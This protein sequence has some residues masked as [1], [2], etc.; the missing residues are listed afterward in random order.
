MPK[1]NGFQ[2]PP[3]SPL[4]DGREF[5]LWR[6]TTTYKNVLFVDQQHVG[7]ADT[8]SG[9]EHAPFKTVQRAAEVVTPGTRVLIKSGIY[10]ECVSPHRG[11]SSQD[12]MISFEAAPGAHVV[13][14]GSEIL[15]GPWQLTGPGKVSVNVWMTDLP[16]ELFVGEHPFAL[17]NT[18]DEEFDIMRWAKH[19]RGKVP[20]TLR[21]AIVLQNGRRLTH[22]ASFED[23]SRVPGSFWI[24]ADN[25]RLHLNPLGRCHPDTVTFEATVRQYLFNPLQ[26]DLGFIKIKGLIFEHAGN[27]FVRSGNGAVNTWSGHH[28]IIENNTVRHINAVG[29]E[30]GAWIDEGIERAPREELEERTGDHVVCGNH[31]HDCGTGGIQGTVVARGLILNN[32]IHDCGW[33][34]AEPYWEV[35][36]IKILYTVDTLVQSNH[37]HDCYAGSAIWIDFMNRNTR[38]CR[39]LIHDVSAFTGAIFFEASDAV[40]MVDH[41]VVYRVRGSG[42]YQHDCDHLVIAHNLVADC[43]L[44]GIRMLKN[45]DRD[46]VGFCRNNRVVNNVVARCEVPLE[47]FDVEN[48]SD[49]NVFT[50]IGEEFD[51]AS[52]Q[53]AGLDARSVILQLEITL[54]DDG[55]SWRGTE[56]GTVPIDEV[57]NCDYFGR[58]LEGCEM[59]VGPFLEG[60]STVPRH[61]SL[62]DR[63]T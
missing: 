13:I 47:Y 35:A 45:K 39:N 31:V 42:L 22:L 49:Q 16:E 55:M 2:A 36:G 10:R 50:G 25:R 37:L 44:A 3:L 62:T 32:L 29:I 58:R 15:D 40:N 23:V 63:S 27:G 11:G 20:H 43:S 19:V 52:W 28:W 46:R 18:T 56:F 4:P 30:I 24:D 1:S 26:T 61:L 57:L 14:R 6:D 54:D 5:A 60:W 53:Q 12:T 33:Q 21:R 8:N 34:E 41:N 51:L 17:E 7:A 9:T 59:P 48:H 38:V